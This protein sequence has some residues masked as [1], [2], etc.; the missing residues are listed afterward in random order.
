MKEYINYD[1][2]GKP[3]VWMRPEICAKCEGKCQWYSYHYH[4]HKEKHYEMREVRLYIDNGVLR[5]AGDKYQAGC[6]YILEHV[7]SQDGSQLQIDDRRPLNDRC[8][9][10]E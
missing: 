1:S 10:V 6:P 5:A 9:K 2:E 7:V 8:R 4:Q 3:W